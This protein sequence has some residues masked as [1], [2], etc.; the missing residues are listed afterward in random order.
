MEGN[1]GSLER[2]E[3][4]RKITEL[5]RSMIVELSNGSSRMIAIDRF[6]SYCSNSLENW[7]NLSEGKD[8]L[9]LQ[10]E[11]HVRRLDVLLRVLLIIQQLLGEN[12]HSSKR[13]IYYMHPSIFTD[14]SVVDRAI[15]D[16][17]ILLQCS[18]HNLNVVSVGNGLV[19][20]WLRFSEAGRRFDCLKKPN[21]AHFIPVQVEE[22][23]DITSAADY[24]LVVEKESVFQRLAN[25]RFC[26]RNRCIVITGRGYPDVPS[27]RFLRLLVDVLAL[28]A[29]CLVDCDPYGFDIL[30][31]YRF[32]SMQMAYDAKYLK[33]PQLRWLG[34][35]ASDFEKYNLPE[36][37]LIPLTFKGAGSLMQA[38]RAHTRTHTHTAFSN[39][40]F[41][42]SDMLKVMFNLSD[43][44]RTEALLQRCYLRREVQHWRLE[45]ESMLERGVKFEIEALSVHNISFLSDE[46]LPS[47]IESELTLLNS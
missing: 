1:R 45:L 38:H 31:T 46:Y 20:G 4:M 40:I 29:F 33:I 11:S 5:T 44:S 22:V 12:R 2:I 30:T 3:V 15:N 25:D 13:D 16:I 19:M 10:R 17:C 27:R 34:A 26:S 6:K 14:Q 41:C 36:Q 9:T 39:V 28:P 18:R 8:V 43:K 23:I 7:F 21:S 47:K 32:G 24:I 35:F 42:I 37:C